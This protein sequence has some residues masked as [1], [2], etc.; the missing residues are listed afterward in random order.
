M[1][2]TNPGQNLG[3]AAQARGLH[4]VPRLP[5]AGHDGAEHASHVRH[6]GCAG[7]G[8]PYAAAGGR[9]R[10][11]DRRLRSVVIPPGPQ[12]KGKQT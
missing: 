5:Q 7:G 11:P 4:A 9:R 6:A 8:G 12:G 2:T 3:I 1:S 10:R